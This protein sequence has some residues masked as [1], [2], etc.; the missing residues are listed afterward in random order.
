MHILLYISR[1]KGDQTIIPGESIEYNMRNSFLKNHAQNVVNIP[2]FFS[3]K[4]KLSVSLIR[5]PKVLYSLFPLNVK[6]RAIK[7]Y[8]ETKLETTCF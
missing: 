7:I 8:C 5:K 1:N 3:K 6:L 2:G 4:S